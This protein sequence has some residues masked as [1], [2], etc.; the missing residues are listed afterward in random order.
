MALE[1]KRLPGLTQNPP[2]SQPGDHGAA[3]L[4]TQQNGD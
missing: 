3:Y 1:A 2:L 4:T